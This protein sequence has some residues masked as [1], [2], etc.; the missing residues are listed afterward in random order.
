MRL[1]AL[2]LAALAIDANARAEAVVETP[3]G[4]PSDPDT[5]ATRR[6]FNAGQAAYGKQRYPEAIAE[7]EAARAITPLPAFDYN[8]ARCYERLERWHDAA[9]SY[10][11]FVAAL[12]SDPESA[13]LRER[14]AT[15]RARPQSPLG[16]PPPSSR[17]P[18]IGAAVVAVV[19]VGLA[20]G[21]VGAE[22]APLADFNRTTTSCNMQCD[23][24]GSLLRGLHDEITRAQIAAGVLGGL[25]AVAAIIDVVLWVK[26]RR[27][28]VD[29][30][31]LAPSGLG[32][33]ATR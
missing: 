21:A 6:H 18:V 7:F 4:A 12:P 5:D 14:I 25:A 26:A 16:A 11:R 17:R 19:A 9:D 31:W 24:N 13:A 32:W 22:L 20:A 15:L 27:R 8:I 23:P 2:V 29:R 3:V 28:T 1:I 30:A 10:A 33:A